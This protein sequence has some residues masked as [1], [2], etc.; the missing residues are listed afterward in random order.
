MNARLQTRSHSSLLLIY[1]G[2]TFTA[3]AVI[4]LG[5]MAIVQASA[6]LSP[7]GPRDKTV[8][9][10]QV[11]SAREIRRAL[12]VP[13]IIQPLPPITARMAR[14]PRSVAS[15]QDRK[16]ARTALSQE[17]LNAM[18]MGP[19]EAPRPARNSY[20]DRHAISF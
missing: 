7:A 17:A 1:I 4:A 18:A 8:L 15:A 12:A 19:S 9:E 20:L 6:A 13:V 16:P 2:A 5:L 10:L 3:L 11:E 14:D